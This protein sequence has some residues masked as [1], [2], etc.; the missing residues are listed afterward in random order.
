MDD[1]LKRFEEWCADEMGNTVGFIR[2]MRSKNI[3]GAIV[4][5]REE[6]NKRYRAWMA[7]IRSTAG[8]KVKE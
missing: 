6:I 4:Y 7:A 8:I 5:K 1:N 2:E 3:L